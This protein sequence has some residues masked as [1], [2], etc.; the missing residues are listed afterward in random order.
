MPI[1]IG[2]SQFVVDILRHS[3][4]RKS[5]EDTNNPQGHSSTEYGDQAAEFRGQ[6]HGMYQ[7]GDRDL[8]LGSH[9]TLQKISRS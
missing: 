7:D 2:R 9:R 1:G 3:K 8:A 6:N 4:R 5:Q